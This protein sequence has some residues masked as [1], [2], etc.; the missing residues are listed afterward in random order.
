MSSSRV[1]LFFKHAHFQ[2]LYMIEVLELS[3]CQVWRVYKNLWLSLTTWKGITGFSV[4]SPDL[5]V[6]STSISLLWLCFLICYLTP[7]K[8]TY[9][10]HSYIYE[11][12]NHCLSSYFFLSLPIQSHLLSTYPTH[13]IYFYPHVVIQSISLDSLLVK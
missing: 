11:R 12:D 8:E 4:D 10:V 13:S 7:S 6:S 2:L 5:I 9:I 3:S 1:G